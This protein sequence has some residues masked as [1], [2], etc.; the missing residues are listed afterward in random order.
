MY[1]K[2]NF[3]IC[4]VFVKKTAKWICLFLPPN[5]IKKNMFFNV[6]W[7]NLD[8]WNVVLYLLDF[9][10]SEA[11]YM[12]LIGLTKRATTKNH[13]FTD[14]D[15]FWI[16]LFFASETLQLVAFRGRCPFRQYIPS[17]PAKYG[18]KF[19]ACVG[20]WNRIIICLQHVTIYRQ[21][22]WPARDGTRGPGCE[23]TRRTLAADWT[24]YHCWQFLCQQRIGRVP[25][26]QE[27]NSC[28]NNKEQQTRGAKGDALQSSKF[29]FTGMMTLVS[30]VPKKNKKRPP[31]YRRCTMIRPSIRN[32]R[33][34]KWFIFYNSTKGRCRHRRSDV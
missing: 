28:G 29:L 17:K 19:W 11:P 18:L 16:C 33:N 26:E 27:D 4:L 25:A 6:F 3:W 8:F 24:E 34:Q 30:Y 21:A 5:W 9:K 2:T 10:D 1:F 20:Q 14:N 7:I 23:G 32:Q 12:E 13:L 15:Q 22:R 31:C